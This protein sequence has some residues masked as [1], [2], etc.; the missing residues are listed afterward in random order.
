MSLGS[1]FGGGD[2]EQTTNQTAY[3]QQVATN[4]AGSPAI[5]AYGNLQT[6]QS[7]RVGGNAKA[8]GPGGVLL[9][10]GAKVV[11]SGA[12]NMEAKGNITITNNTDPAALA[13]AH[14]ALA[15]NQSLN[16]EVTEAISAL[17][18]D[19]LAI[20][21][22]LADPAN[23]IETEPT[24]HDPNNTEPEATDSSLSKLQVLG[25]VALVAGAGYLIYKRF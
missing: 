13:M 24:H 11:S 25:I 7:M 10:Q 19:S 5:G 2:S 21:Q 14:E 16:K 15:A 22:S 18:M 20:A 17:H 1:L 6:G 8:V 12:V 9:E 3:N 4:G 23:H